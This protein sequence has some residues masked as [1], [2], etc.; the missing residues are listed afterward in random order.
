MKILVAMSG[1]VDSSA[2]ALMIK[3]KGHD[4]SGAIMH[5]LGDKN[6]EA[7]TAYSVAEKIGIPFYEFD[8]SSEF[9]SCVIDKF[10]KCYEEG[11]TP[12]PCIDCNRNLKFGRFFEEAEKLGFSGIATGHYARIEKSGNNYFIKK[13][14]DISKDQSY[15]LYSVKRELLPYILMPLGEYSKEEIREYA[16]SHGFIN[17]NKKDSQDICFVPDGDY[18]KIIAE[19]SKK[20]YPEGEFVTLD[21]KVLGRHKGI[22]GYTIGQRKGLGLALPE[23]MYVCEKNVETN[24]VIL[25]LSEDLMK[26]DMNVKD[27]NWLASQ[28]VPDKIRAKVKIRYKQEEQS[29]EINFTEDGARVLF[30]EPQRAISKGQAAVFYDGDTVLGGGTIC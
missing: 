24:R 7:L 28:N 17:A 9:S 26:R 19:K 3:E 21:G 29:A 15:V 16:A 18:A 22:I 25:G 13:A 5:L 10:V 11:G 20:T 12:N 2:A 1:G 6:P 30:D 4:V 23:P 14:K 8:F 27:I